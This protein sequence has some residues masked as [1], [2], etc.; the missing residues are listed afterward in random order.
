[1]QFKPVTGYVD[2]GGA[3]AVTLMWWCV[4]VMKV[5]Q[6]QLCYLGLWPLHLKGLKAHQQFVLVVF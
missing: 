5:H 3:T 1:M 6:A 4:T 2:G